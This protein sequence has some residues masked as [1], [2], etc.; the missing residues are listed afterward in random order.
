MANILTEN[1]NPH[2]LDIDLMS[3]KNILTTINN[4]DKFVHKAVRDAI[5]E[6]TKA[7]DIISDSILNNGRIAY[8]G[9]GTSGRLGVLDASECWPTFSL[10]KEII[11]GYIAGGDFALR[12][13][14]E[15]AEDSID[16]GLKHINN[17]SP[18][19]KDVIVGISASGNPKYLETIFQEAKKNKTKIILITSNPDAKLKKFADICITTIVGPEVITG[20]NRMKSGTAQKMVLNM[21]STTSMIKIGKTYGNLMVD[22]QPVCNKLIDRA[23]RII[24]AICEIPIEI[25]DNY[26]IKANNN[27]KIACV[28][29]KKQCTQEEASLLL[30]KQ[31]GILRKV[32]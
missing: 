5:P 9:A 22:V 10:P 16:E 21:L 30:K 19:K 6:I 23:N 17:F 15:G 18:T 27:V 32:I 2:S 14:I 24:S 13:S 8:F 11:T 1:S 25:A 12:N 26:R 31:N 4:E 29:Y 3:T 7:V 20:S 28:M